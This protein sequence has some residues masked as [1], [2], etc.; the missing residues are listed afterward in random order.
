MNLLEPDVERMNAIF[1]SL[2][3]VNPALFPNLKIK[4]R[5]CGSCYVVLCDYIPNRIF[6]LNSCFK[7]SKK[8]SI[9]Y[10]PRSQIIPH[11]LCLFRVRME[12]GLY[13]LWQ[14]L[15]LTESETITINI[16]LAKLMNPINAL[17]GRLAMEKFASIFDLEKWL[18]SICDLKTPLKITQIGDNLYMFEL[19]DKK[20]CDRIFNKQPWNFRSSLLLLEH[21]RGNECPPTSTCRRPPSGFKPLQIWAMTKGTGKDIGGLLGEVLEVKSDYDGVIMG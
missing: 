9:Q 2:K 21:I 19:I 4:V 14:K 16:D 10:F 1:L 15:S 11:Y 5:A 3:S 17:V 18:K 13:S 12:D 6:R 20:V 7:P 8:H